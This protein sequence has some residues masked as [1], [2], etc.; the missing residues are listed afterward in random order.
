[1]RPRLLLG[2]AAGATLAAALWWRKNP[3][4]CPYGQR[5]WVEAPHP[6][7]TR[8]RLRQ[9]L[10]PEPGERLL[11]IGVGTGYYSLDLAEWVAPSGK[12]ELFDLQQEFLDH[13]MRAAGERGM[14]NM[15][16]TRGDATALPFEDASVDA[17]VLTAVLGEIPDTAAAL[18]EIRR[19][20]KPE[21]RLVVGELF[22]DPHFTTL[23]SL[24][25]RAAE[26]G[27]VYAEHSGNKLAYFARLG[28][29]PRS[30]V[31][32]I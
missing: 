32:P 4:A 25:R 26:A 10:R 29:S 20:L 21:G 6:V 3:S 17:V 14:T 18:R 15:V 31:P 2:A 16:P 27:L 23:A 11:E 19:V 13:V 12:L 28:L 5:F 9:I 22:G 7:I 24:K 1:M 8:D 30:G